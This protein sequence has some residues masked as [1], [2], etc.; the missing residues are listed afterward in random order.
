LR[1]PFALIGF[2]SHQNFKRYA[3]VRHC[4]WFLQSLTMAAVMVAAIIYE[5]IMLDGLNYVYLLG[6]AFIACVI[7]GLDYHFTTVV[8]FYSKHPNL[9][10]QPIKWLSSDSEPQF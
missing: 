1:W 5:V 7:V 9:T 6:A 3:R 10:K 8:R 4:T 2:T